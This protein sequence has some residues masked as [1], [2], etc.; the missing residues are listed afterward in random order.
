MSGLG[1][2]V[3]VVLEQLG[4]AEVNGY[5]MDQ[6]VMVFA[7]SA[8]RDT[9]IP[10]PTEGMVSYLKDTNSLEFYETTWKALVANSTLDELSDVTITSATTGNSL[11]WNGTAWVN[12]TLDFNDLGDVDIIAVADGEFIKYDVASSSWINTTISLNDLDDVDVSTPTE[13]SSLYYNG[14]EWVAQVLNVENLG[15]VEIDTLG[16]GD[17]LVYD[18]AT[19]DWV[20][21]GTSYQKTSEKDQPDGYAGLDATGKIDPNQIPSLAIG[22]TFVVADE[23]ARLA[24]TTAETGDIAIQT[25]TSETYILQGTDPAEPTDWV[26]LLFPADAVDSVNGQTGTVVLDLDDINDVAIVTPADG[27]VLTYDSATG[28][29]Y[30]GAAPAG[31]LAGLSDVDV[32]GVADGQTIVYDSGTSEWIPGDAGGKFA[33]SDTA[34]AGPTNGDT[35]FNSATGI[36]YIY[37]VDVDGGQWVQLGGGGGVLALGKILQVVSTTLTSVFTASVATTVFTPITGLT[38]TITPSSATSK[39]L[40]SV[41]LSAGDSGLDGQHYK[42]T[43]GGTDIFIG[44]AASSR[45]RTTT[46]TPGLARSRGI[47]SSAFTVLDSPATTSATTY[48]VDISSGSPSTATVRINRSRDDSNLGEVARGVSTITLMEVAG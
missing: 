12:Q 36:A 41:T 37:Y 46:G 30:N 27:E 28:E 33:V 35:W 6:T 16:D 9:A 2:K 24:L 1:R 25:D 39:I 32:T 34:P 29:W 22:E 18:L 13:D 19:L 21:D 8:A 48:G 45:Q 15:N 42:A 14:F 43:R 11:V 31:T 17:L 47:T 38:A 44:D 20:N 3:F 4:A 7:N 26:K 5:L 23:A 40:V 10:T